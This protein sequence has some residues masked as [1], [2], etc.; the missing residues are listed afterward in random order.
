MALRFGL[1]RLSQFQRDARLIIV[2][3][4]IFAVSFFS[5][6]N[7]SKSVNCDIAVSFVVYI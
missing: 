6:S 3:S 5:S 2:T 4:G 1:P 7:I